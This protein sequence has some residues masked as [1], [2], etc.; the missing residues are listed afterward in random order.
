MEKTRKMEL[1]KRA[2]LAVDLVVELAVNTEKKPLPLPAAAR[3]LGVLPSYLESVLYGLR[4]GK[5]IEASRGPGGGYKLARP[6]TEITVLDV[7]LATKESESVF[8]EVLSQRLN[9]TDADE[10]TQKL[11]EEIERQAVS[12]LKNVSIKD[13]ALSISEAKKAINEASGGH[14]WMKYTTSNTNETLLNSVS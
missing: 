1:P 7:V 4:A 9:G 12:Y 3:L 2:R 14:A 11:L 5:L 13:L 6:A 10:L 8:D